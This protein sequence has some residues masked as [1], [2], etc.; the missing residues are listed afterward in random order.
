VVPHEVVCG[1]WL[2]WWRLVMLVVQP[3]LVFE[4]V[5]A[6]TCVAGSGGVTSVMGVSLLDRSY[7]VVLALAQKR[8]FVS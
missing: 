6:L 2:R 5:P 7:T 8:W 4:P 3:G 1:E